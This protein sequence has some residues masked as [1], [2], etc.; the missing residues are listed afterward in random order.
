ME[1]CIEI[2]RIMTFATANN[3]DIVRRL[4]GCCDSFKRLTFADALNQYR[5][6]ERNGLVRKGDGYLAVY[7]RLA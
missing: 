6:C 4:M 5:Y 2:A 1:G 7:H 3:R